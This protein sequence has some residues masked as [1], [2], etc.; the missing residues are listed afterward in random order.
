MNNHIWFSSY[1]VG[2]LLNKIIVDTFCSK[3]SRHV[4]LQK[5]KYPE[6]FKSCQ[7]NIPH[8]Y[9]NDPTTPK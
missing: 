8:L 1:F 7:K 9:L 5:K 2:T 3:K 6:F 4:A